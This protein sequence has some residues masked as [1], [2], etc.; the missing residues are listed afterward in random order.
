MEKHFFLLGAPLF[1]FVAFLVL[2]SHTF[3]TLIA[4]LCIH[5][6]QACVVCLLLF[7]FGL[8][9]VV[10]SIAWFIIVWLRARIKVMHV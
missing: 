10:M 1:C 6:I 9:H 5:S 2:H 7:G 4:L 3:S 8:L